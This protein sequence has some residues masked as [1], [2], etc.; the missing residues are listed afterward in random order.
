MGIA[1]QEA[2]GLGVKPV[3]EALGC[4][5]RRTTAT[6]GLSMDHAGRGTIRVR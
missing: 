2:N 4:P 1:E 6:S 3:C 5:V